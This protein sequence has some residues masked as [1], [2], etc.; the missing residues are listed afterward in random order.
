MLGDTQLFGNSECLP[1]IRAKSSSQKTLIPIFPKILEHPTVC[2]W[3]AMTLFGHKR[4]WQML[5]ME[6][7][8]DYNALYH[9]RYTPFYHAHQYTQIKAN[10]INAYGTVPVQKNNWKNK[11]KFEITF[12]PVPVQKLF[13]N[14]YQ[15]NRIDSKK[16]D[17]KEIKSHC[18][19]KSKSNITQ[20]MWAHLHK[21][22]F[23][24]NGK[25]LTIYFHGFFPQ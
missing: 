13:Q 21:I 10:F 23:T 20:R 16:S 15:S 2:T 25:I 9:E 5:F 7:G 12:V 11:K 6:K 14:D 3:T 22:L 8:N 4:V 1:A 24:V 18:G 17:A 19:L